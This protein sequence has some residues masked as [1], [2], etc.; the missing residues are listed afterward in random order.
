[1]MTD[2]VANDFFALA[3][4]VVG[5]TNAANLRQMQAA[6]QAV[7]ASYAAET[8]QKA[9]ALAART[10]RNAG[11]AML[12]TCNDLRAEMDADPL[13]EVMY[14]AAYMQSARALVE[15]IALA[16]GQPLDVAAKSAAKILQC[17]PSQLL[18]TGLPS[19]TAE[20]IEQL[21]ASGLLEHNQDRPAPGKRKALGTHGLVH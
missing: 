11:Q 7:I 6:S 10:L 18:M 14:Q 12:K 15:L 5:K 17:D 19:E 9:V 2:Y 13:S 16:G 8:H 21:K 3:E 20:Q 4:Q 1:M